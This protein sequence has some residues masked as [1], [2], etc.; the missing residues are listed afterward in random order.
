[1]S[2][3]LA[4]EGGHDPV[5]LG[6]YR[7]VYR[8][9][10][11]GMGVVH[12]GLDGGGHAVAVKVLRPYAAADP[13][14]RVRLSREVATL[15]RVRHPQVAEVLDAD[16]DGDP[17]YLVTRFVPGLP[18]DG[19]VGRFGPLSPAR[20]AHLGRVLAGAL[21]AIHAA[22]VVHRDVKPGNVV[23][24]DGDPV[25]IDFGIAQLADESRITM[26]GQVMG[27][28]GYLAPEVVGGRYPTP[29]SDWW[30]WA[31]TLAFAATGRPPFGTGPV[32]VVLDRVRRGQPDL[33]GVPEPLRTGLARALSVDPAPRS[34]PAALV[35]GLGAGPAGVTT[36]SVTVPRTR[37]MTQSASAPGRTA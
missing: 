15:R 12:L 6:P 28:P 26:V 4:A 27:T 20:V 29:A 13:L 18:L 11:G 32:E 17:P 24:L 33:H 25:L 16:V 1:M 21:G 7:L 30:S 35:A 37:T 8:I 9:G 10:E 22:G 23:L 14:S 31:A 19:H 36:A 2:A 3:D 5:T 34:D